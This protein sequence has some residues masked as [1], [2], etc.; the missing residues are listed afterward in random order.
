MPTQTFSSFEAFFDAFRFASMRPI[1]LGPSGKNWLLTSVVINNVSI[2]WGHADAKAAVEGAP[3][4]DGVSIFLPT[5]TPT[6]WCWNGCRLD[7]CSVMVDRSGAEFC[8][9]AAA[10]PRSWCGLYIPNLL[11]AG[12]DGD[13]STEVGSKRGAFQV[14]RERITR[15]RSIV[16]QLEAV[17]Q[18][19]PTLLESAAVQS[20]ASQKL[21]R[22]V[23]ELLA[24]PHTVQPKAGRHLL[25]HRQIIRMAMDF[26]E[27]HELECISVEQL[28]IAAGVSERRLRDAFLSYFGLPPVQYLNRRLLNY[29]RKALLT[30]DPSQVTVS[31]VAT[32]FGVWHFGRLARDYRVLF[33]ELPSQTLRHHN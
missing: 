4:A 31:E 33:G 13:V 11:L 29:I 8:L 28:A 9:S 12:A 15:F 3:R 32:Q 24:G 5:R 16:G 2:Q 19:S 17:V 20:A 21:L 25:P 7:E 30:S 27:E 10:A 14:S 23:R 26:V 1:I 6:A 18:G 22:E